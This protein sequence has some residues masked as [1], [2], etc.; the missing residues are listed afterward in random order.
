M[1]YIFLRTEGSEIFGVQIKGIVV[2]A[3][4]VM[5][6]GGGGV[7][8]LYMMCWPLGIFLTILFIS[9]LIIADVVVVGSCGV[10]S[11]VNFVNLLSLVL[12]LNKRGNN[13]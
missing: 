1:L 13:F 3:W 10:I 7:E 6:G 4:V 2:S 8:S 5:E 9:S 11:I 12:V